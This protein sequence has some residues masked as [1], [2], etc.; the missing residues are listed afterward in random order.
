M[1]ETKS[2]SAEK[3][4]KIL[5]CIIV[6]AICFVP[7]LCLTLRA[8]PLNFISDET[9]SLSIAAAVAGYNWDDVVSQAGYYGIGFLWIFAPLF[10][11]GLSPVVIYRIIASVLAGVNALTGP[12]F[13]C[14][15]GRFF[16]VQNRFRKTVVASI[17]GNLILFYVAS[18]ATRNEEILAL[19]VCVAAY[20]ICRIAEE[21]KFRDEIL[22]SLV[23]LYSLTCHTRAVAI[24]L[25]VLVVSILYSIFYRKKF[26]HIAT[27][28]INIVGYVVVYYLLRLYRAGVWGSGTVRNSSVS[29]SVSNAMSNILS[30]GDIGD[31]VKSWIRIVGGQIF[32]ASSV[33]GGLF[34]IA[35]IVCIVYLVYFFKKKK[36]N[37]SEA[38]F[39]L[40][41]T[42]LILVYGTIFTQGVTWLN[43]VYDGI[44]VQESFTY[45]YGYKAFTYLRY[46][47]PYVPM[48]VMTA[49][50][51][52]E[53][54]NVNPE[55]HALLKRSTIIAV[56]CYAALLILWIKCILPFMY[57]NKPEYLYFLAGFEYGV[58]PQLANWISVFIIG[59]AVLAL[60]LIVGMKN[61]V[62]IA[63]VASLALLACGQIATFQN[64][65]IH[66]MEND[67]AKAD[68]GYNLI[69]EM[70]DIL[71]ED[72]Y[73]C[74][75]SSATDHQIWYMYQFLNYT[76]HI[77]PDI[78]E[79]TEDDFILFTNK[80][81]DL[82]GENINGYKLD[83]N[84]YVYTNVPEY[85]E[86]IH[87]FQ[88][89][90]E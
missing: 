25:T 9:S 67:Y 86:R 75:L 30:I 68:S 89:V 52:W 1:E 12:I 29:S 81:T 35:T 46:C 90:G 2:I 5:D 55:K 31:V 63:L 13:Y 78:P 22:L 82:E 50:C 84:E 47:G 19:L 57:P 54:D 40:A 53:N 26:F 83:N 87:D 7:R 69:Q 88:S 70:S 21:R 11:M 85:K 34:L 23:M 4:K 80:K 15:M 39:V 42:G 8:Y 38:L 17:C 71:E 74:D 37:A 79:N 36:E 20:L 49:F 61:H 58:D 10:K 32:T 66:S 44:Y 73:V 64:L 45:V 62:G 16:H 72:I 41:F 14:M 28:I 6:F 48:L 65:T 18:M 27:Y 77:I 60:Y 59:S 3:K 51:C 24:I 76:Y 33:T 43:G 56:P